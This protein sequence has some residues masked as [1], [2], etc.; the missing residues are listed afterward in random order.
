MKNLSIEKNIAQNKTL[1]LSEAYLEFNLGF[2]IFILLL[3]LI[4]ID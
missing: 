4:R 2:K 3:Y 1:L